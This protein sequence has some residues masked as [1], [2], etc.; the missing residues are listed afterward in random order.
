MNSA[1]QLLALAIA[2]AGPML[3][4]G[5][6]EPPTLIT[7]DTDNYVIYREDPP[8]FARYGTNA[9]PPAAATLPANFGSFVGIGDIVA[10]NG[11]PARGLF[12]H[13]AQ[14][15]LTS[16]NPTPGQAIADVSRGTMSQYLIEVLRADGSPI[17]TLWTAG[18]AGLYVPPGAP[19]IADGVPHIIVGGSGAYLGARGQMNGAPRSDAAPPRLTTMVEDPANRRSH[20]GGRRRDVV[21]LIPL[22]VP[23]IVAVLH[24]NF[25][26]VTAANP[27]RPGETL[28]VQAT[29]M[30]P[31]RATID[32][33]YPFPNPP[34]EISSPVEVLVDGVP[35]AALNQIGWPGVARRYR[36]D[37]RVPAPVSGVT[38][39]LSL[40]SGY[41]I[42]P[43]TEVPIAVR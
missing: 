32:P 36:V 37:F 21:H 30:G 16:S 23:R 15:I 9:N 38:T 24:D 29:G 4:I 33:G 27:A 34:A 6:T 42:G 17:G 1:Y 43:Q 3:L 31:L 25:A 7:I 2:M 11:R 22:E 39:Q 35:Q 5:Q 28:I 13:R 41:I 20:G 19:A 18:S 10:V 14:Q 12:V 8:N 40:M 26:P